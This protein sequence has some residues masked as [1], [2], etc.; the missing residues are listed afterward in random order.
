MVFSTM[1]TVTFSL[2][3]IVGVS[4]IGGD[5]SIKDGFA[6]TTL[7]IVSVAVLRA[8][9]AFIHVFHYDSPY[10]DDGCGVC[11]CDGHVLRDSAVS[12]R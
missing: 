1:L 4:G 8:T 9:G 12:S 7:Q 11:D 5:L 6:L 10:R 3:M 2:M